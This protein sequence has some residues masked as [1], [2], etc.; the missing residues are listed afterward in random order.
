MVLLSKDLG[1]SLV[2]SYSYPQSQV[3]DFGGR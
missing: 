2:I 1:L 3:Q